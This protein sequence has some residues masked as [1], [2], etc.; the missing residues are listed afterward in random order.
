MTVTEHL[1]PCYLTLLLHAHT[2]ISLNMGQGNN[3]QSGVRGQG[4][5]GGSPGSGGSQGTTR[6]SVSNVGALPHLT[7]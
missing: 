3:G 6:V 7:K 2:I 5:S 1:I 4:C